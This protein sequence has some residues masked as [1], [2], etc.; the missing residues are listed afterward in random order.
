LEQY[1][2]YLYLLA[3]LKLGPQVRGKLD[4]SD[5]VQEALLQAHKNAGQFR[6]HTEAERVAWL[7][8]ILATTLAGALRK[9]AT[10][11]R[12]LANERSLQA[13]LDE[14]SARLEQWLALDQSSPSQRAS[15]TEQLV[16]LADALL[17]L[18]E[19]QRQ[20]VELHHLQG[21]SVAEVAEHLGKSKAAIAGLLFRGLK[22]L[23]GILQEEG[24]S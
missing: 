12:D 10:R 21:Y 18:P 11:A 6:G 7:R 13:A 23:R 3:R 1:R 20:A 16:L 15:R 17:Q 8:R 2:N 4:A 5:V 9:F 19:E 24:E 22:Q 14:S